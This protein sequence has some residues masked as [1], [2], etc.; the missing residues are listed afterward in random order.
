MVAYF[1]ESDIVNKHDLLEPWDF[2]DLD[3]LHIVTSK[4]KLTLLY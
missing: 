2:H 4:E 1:Q 3:R